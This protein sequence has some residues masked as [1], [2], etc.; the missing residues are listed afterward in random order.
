MRFPSCWIVA[1]RYMSRGGKE[2][3]ELPS[4]HTFDTIE[5]CVLSSKTCAIPAAHQCQFGGLV[6]YISSLRPFSFSDAG[7]RR[8][9]G[10]RVWHGRAGIV[11]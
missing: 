5:A 2:M 9:V 11:G 6:A 10:G 3:K 4:Y 1:H 7:C 8:S